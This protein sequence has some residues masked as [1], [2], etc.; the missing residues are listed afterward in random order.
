M[1]CKKTGELIR[2]LRTEKNMTQKQLAD[3]MNISDKTVS[4]WERG[5]G[6]PDVSLLEELSSALGVNIE[7]ILGG[8]LQINEI[9]GGNMK[10]SKFYVCPVCGN[11]AF[12]TGAAEMSCCGRKL[13]ALQP[14]KA[15]EDDMLKVEFV[16]NERFISSDHPMTKENYISF[17]AFLT[18]GTVYMVKQYPEWNM[19]LRLPGRIHG[20]LIWYSTEK[21][22]LYQLL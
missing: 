20:K 18:G 7:Q 4:K 15:G 19:Q 10:N 8:S 16:E 6:C 17:A 22:L 11:I 21:G 3:M 9:V 12:C 14:Q 5:L 1:D 2:L 13:T